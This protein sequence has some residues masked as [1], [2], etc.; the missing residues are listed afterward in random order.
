MWRSFSPVI[1]IF[2]ENDLDSQ[3]LP[4]LN[5]RLRHRCV[6]ASAGQCQCCTRL[7][8][9]E[10]V[11]VIALLSAKVCPSFSSHL[12]LH[13]GSLAMPACGFVWQQSLPSDANSQFQKNARGRMPLSAPRQ[14]PRSPQLA[15]SVTC[16]GMA[17]ALACKSSLGDVI[18]SKY[19]EVHTHP[20]KALERS[21]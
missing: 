11:T 19:T 4:S 13:R 2:P 9:F 21:V 17:R 6:R 18:H 1:L 15:V 20:L 12:Y 8:V 14:V 7:A 3:H 16:R 10:R 5:G